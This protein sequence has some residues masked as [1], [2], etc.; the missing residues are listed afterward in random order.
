MTTKAD[1]LEITSD[2]RHQPRAGATWS[3][4]AELELIGRVAQVA[5]QLLVFERAYPRSPQRITDQAIGRLTVDPPRD[6]FAERGL[7]RRQHLHQDEGRGRE[8]EGVDKRVPGARA[9]S[10]RGR[11]R[12]PAEH[13]T[14]AEDEKHRQDTEQ[15]VQ[16]DGRDSE[17]GAAFR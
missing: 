4:V 13:D 15:D 11:R 12:H 10:R 3:A 14:R 6:Q 5:E 7:K 8:K 17:A 9:D 16:D 2:Q 1:Q